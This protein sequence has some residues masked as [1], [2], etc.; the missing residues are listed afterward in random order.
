MRLLNL[1][2]LYVV[3]DSLCLDLVDGQLAEVGLGQQNDLSAVELIDGLESVRFELRLA[4]FVFVLF[5]EDGVKYSLGFDFS[6]HVGS[7]DGSC[8]VFV[9][10]IA[11]LGW[12]DHKLFEGVV[13]VLLVVVVG[14][15]FNLL[16]FVLAF[17]VQGVFRLLFF[18]SPLFI[19]TFWLQNYICDC[20]RLG[21][22]QHVDKAHEVFNLAAGVPGERV[23]VEAVP[24]GQQF[25]IFF[26]GQ[27]LLRE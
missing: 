2:G 1:A 10:L 17:I 15:I 7:P 26:G 11:V 6:S 12:N 27:R 20:L 23:E 21:Q 5:V 13:E 14:R 24:D 18:N 8:C 4:Y 25:Y 22:L 19:V 9:G 3:L 16:D